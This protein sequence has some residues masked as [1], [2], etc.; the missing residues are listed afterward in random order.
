MQMIAS[1]DFT[2][3]MY[4]RQF[5]RDPRLAFERRPNLEKLVLGAD[6]ARQGRDSFALLQILT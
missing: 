1:Q 2:M 3:D 6:Y 4:F 5:W